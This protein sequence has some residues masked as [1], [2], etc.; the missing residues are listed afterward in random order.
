MGRFDFEKR[1]DKP[2][3]NGCA[4]VASSADPGFYPQRPAAQLF[5]VP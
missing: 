3:E 5:E 4:R 1:K 2:A